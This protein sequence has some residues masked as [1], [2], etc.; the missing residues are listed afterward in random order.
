MSCRCAGRAPWPRCRAARGWRAARPAS[1]Q[2]C[3]TAQARTPCHLHAVLASAQ[4]CRGCGAGCRRHATTRGACSCGA[5]PGPAALGTQYTTRHAAQVAQQWQ[6]GAWA[7]PAGVCT[8]G[9]C[10]P[11]P[12]LRPPRAAPGAVKPSWPATAATVAGVSPDRM[13]TDRP[14][15]TPTLRLRW[16]EQQRQGHHE[17][18]KELGSPGRGQ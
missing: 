18:G 12:H 10:K 16:Q 5:W 14:C 3:G 4:V 2:G 1:R 11:W 13:C 17:R 6:C 8:G 15:S 9:P 7:A